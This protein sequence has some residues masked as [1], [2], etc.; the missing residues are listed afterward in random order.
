MQHNTVSFYSKF[1]FLL[2]I[3]LYHYPLFLNYWNF[4]KVL[5]EYWQFVNEFLEYFDFSQKIIGFYSLTQGSRKKFILVAVHIE[6]VSRGL[7]TKK[8]YL[9][10]K[11]KKIPQKNVATKFKGGPLG[12]LQ[13]ELFLRLPFFYEPDPRYLLRYF[14]WIIRR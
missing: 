8:K 13:K 11:H 12:P 4:I 2:F 7:A 1:F 10:L 9:F 6:G 3:I 5:D 14:P